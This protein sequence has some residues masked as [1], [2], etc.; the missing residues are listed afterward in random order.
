MD[1]ER[2]L[3]RAGQPKLAQY[4]IGKMILQECGTFD[5]DIMKQYGVTRKDILPGVICPD[6]GLRGIERKHSGWWCSKCKQKYY[7]A[8]LKALADYFLL[9]ND[10]ITNTECMRFLQLTSRN[11][12]TRILKASGLVYIEKHR[13]WVWRRL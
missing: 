1:K 3:A 4:Q 8:H 9:V 10:F 7:N 6:C 5:K 13:H 11:T 2:E 12:A